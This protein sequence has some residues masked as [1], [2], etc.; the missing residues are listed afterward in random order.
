MT[1]R[2]LPSTAL[3]PQI[4]ILRMLETENPTPPLGYLWHAANEMPLRHYIDTMSDDDPTLRSIFEVEYPADD[5]ALIAPALHEGPSLEGMRRET[6]ISVKP[7][8][9]SADY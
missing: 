9:D 7:F 4:L 3:R 8:D 2:I 5:V 6:F 1:N